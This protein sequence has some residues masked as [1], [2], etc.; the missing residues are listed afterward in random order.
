MIVA[1]SSLKS[2]LGKSCQ[3]CFRAQFDLNGGQVAYR[4]YLIKYQGLSKKS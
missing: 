2:A 1:F 3:D 4:D